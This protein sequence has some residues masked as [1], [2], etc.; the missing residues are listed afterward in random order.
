MKM[1]ENQSIDLT[2][3]FTELQAK[4]E[5]L[6]FNYAHL[7]QKYEVLRCALFGRSSEK[8]STAERLQLSLSFNEAEAFATADQEELAIAKPEEGT[9][10]KSHKRKK[11]RK[12]LP[13]DLPRQEIIYDLDEE[14]KLCPCGCNLSKIGEERSEQLDYIPAKMQVLVHVRYKY[15]CKTCEDTV[16]LASV[17][18]K[19]LPKAN[20]SAGLLAH[21]LVSKYA[22]HLP[23]YRQS[24]I[25]AR[26]GI[27]IADNTLCNWVI[28]CGKIMTPLVQLLQADIVASDYVCSDETPL[29]VLASQK[30]NS[31]MWVHLSGERHKRAIVY[32]YHDSREGDCAK[33]FLVGFKGYHQCD[34]YAGYQELHTTAEICWI[35]CF[36]H[37]RRKFIEITKVVKTPGIAHQVVGLIGKLYKVER[38]AMDRRLYPEDI[39]KLRD[40][41]SR[42]ILRELKELLDTVASKTPPQSALGKAIAYSLNH[43]AGLTAYLLDGRLRIDNNDTERIIKP[44]ALGRKNWLFCKTTRGADASSKIYSLIETCK[45]NKVEPYAYLR[46]VLDN[47]RCDMMPEELRIML[48]YNIDKNFLTA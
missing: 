19:P 9:E 11:G 33:N 43:W 14:Q 42:P 46:Y 4:Y 25:F 41:K 37:A 26:H 22:D 45:A 5:N 24:Q 39:K 21:I 1:I 12:P 10:V 15:A 7:L 23:L 31:Y 28:G 3:R 8:L 17:P 6:E 47:I 44:F 2:E 18:A 29:R 40:A 32:D 35:A 27:D 36:A 48:P 30:S 38:E 34:A 20:A 16:R 13:K